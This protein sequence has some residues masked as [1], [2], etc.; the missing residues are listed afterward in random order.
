MK[1]FECFSDTGY[2]SSIIT[3]FNVDFD[4]Y[5]TVVLP[6]L[7]EAGC[8]NN[9][10][11]A[12]ARMLGHSINSGFNMPK[13]A[14]RH[15][16]VIG[17]NPAGVFH[18]KLILQLGDTS[19]RLLVTSANMT[20]PGIAGNL[21]VIGEV[22]T[23][24]EDLRF[25]PVLRAA[26]EYVS[27][28]LD[29]S[30]VSGRQIEW[31]MTRTSWLRESLPSE[32]LVA[33]PDGD[34]IGF[35]ASN[36]TEGIGSRFIELVG[37]R[38]VKRL[39]SMSPYWDGDLSM[40]DTLKRNLTPKSTVVLIQPDSALFPKLSWSTDKSATLFSVNGI[41]GMA[42]NRF[43]HAKLLIAETAERDC[44]LYGSA[45][46][47]EPALGTKS[48]TNVNEEVCI[49]RELPPGKTAKLLGLEDALTK[50]IALKASDLPD[51]KPG[52]EIPIAD[53]ERRLPGRFE[54]CGNRLHWW[55]PASIQPS[56]ADVRLFTAEGT[57][58][59]AK[60]TC[61]RTQSKH[62]VYL[63]ES[64]E[65]PHL[66]QVRTPGFESSFAIISVEQAIQES[67]RRSMTKTV[68][69]ALSLLDDD[70]FEGM[71]LL[72]VIQKIAAA[73]HK[74]KAEEGQF[75]TSRRRPV[76]VDIHESS[77]ILSYEKFIDGRT[78]AA[79]ADIHTGSQ[80]A[81]S[82]HESVR[83]FINALVGKNSNYVNDTGVVDVEPVA[84]FSLGDET[85]DGE[86]AIEQ[87]LR[88]ITDRQLSTI[89]VDAEKALLKRKQKYVKDTQSSV[90]K[91][92]ERLL[93]TLR[94]D[95]SRRRF[96]AVDLL[97]LRTMLMV[98]LW[99]GSQKIDL[100]SS[101]RS[102][103]MTSRQVLPIAG[104]IN[105]REL[106]Y[107]IIYTFFRCQTNGPGPLVDNVAIN[108]D[109]ELGLPEDVLECWAT[110]YWALCATRVAVDSH[111]AP[112]TITDLENKTAMDLY[113]YTRLTPEEA[114]G[115]VVCTIFE[116]MNKRYGERLGAVD[117]AVMTE[118][119]KLIV[120][121]QR[122]GPPI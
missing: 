115:E 49:Y 88:F 44:V 45:N 15:Y 109:S 86:T 97:R 119:E 43:A 30:S 85:N 91:A 110:C 14:G 77:R 84:D 1:L 63:L 31:A 28:F 23:R 107:K 3:T 82:N 16:S 42:A 8:N 83:T 19:G 101:D 25:L 58:I 92:V 73:E 55:P 2:H 34:I 7:R 117:V 60:L 99:L 39:I 80:L 52:A 26:I 22:L 98:I 10:L 32:P 36:P 59:E 54:L 53:L 114:R 78:D 70:A 37:K 90:A 50:S 38:K 51:Y 69:S 67:Q 27:Q 79:S 121:S 103:I 9:I 62:V 46:C 35:L 21:E 111:G 104:K 100:F 11:I 33:T 113:R 75:R 102:S 105:W 48:A 41:K 5:E 61:L 57:S 6:R 120:E 74:P 47:T 81:S 122:I 76:E 64:I 116:G 56:D 112:F 118:H 106:T 17:V 72:E 65:S 93:R 71:W 94:E 4:T 12:D 96:G 89:S 95:F 87:D 66:A 18:P 13:V 20:T 29:P 24:D 68:E 108:A 40:F